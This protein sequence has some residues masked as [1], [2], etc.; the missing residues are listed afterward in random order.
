MRAP[1]LR[2][3]EFL[4]LTAAVQR[5]YAGS[6]GKC[7]NPTTRGNFCLLTKVTHVDEMLASVV[8]ATAAMAKKQ[9]FL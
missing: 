9:L 1:P 2:P 6:T 7:A 4:L 5:S 8:V 3:P